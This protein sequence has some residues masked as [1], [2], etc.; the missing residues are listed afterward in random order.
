MPPPVAEPAPLLVPS[1][2][3]EAELALEIQARRELE[4][5]VAM[6]KAK[7][8]EKRQ[9][10]Q[11]RQSVGGFLAGRAQSSARSK[12][13]TQAAGGAETF[14]AAPA[15]SASSGSTETFRQV[16]GGV[17]RLKSPAEIAR[18]DSGKLYMLGLEEVKRF[19][20][21]RGLGGE[22][23]G[24]NLDLPSIMTYLQA[25]FHGHLPQSQMGHR[26]C[27]EIATVGSCLDALAAGDLPHLGDLLMQRFKKLELEA[28]EGDERAGETLELLPSR[29][30]GLAG[31]QELEAA[32]A[33]E[34]RL[35]KVHNA[36]RGRRGEPY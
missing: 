2:I 30:V 10:E 35:A 16:S 11:R 32:Q 9:E 5:K 27:R 13:A 28:Q 3:A 4:D 34:I 23:S 1:S 15:A 36:R 21:N 24:A 18:E 17:S 22:Q 19:L 6:L 29:A 20:G 25:I 8:E 26:A 31:Q 33:E 7:L 12:E 14:L